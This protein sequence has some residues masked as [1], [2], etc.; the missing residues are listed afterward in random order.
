MGK[1]EELASGGT[2]RSSDKGARL[3]ALESTSAPKSASA[4]EADF[5]TSSLES[6]MLN[7]KSGKALKALC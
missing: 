5:S 2:R 7:S 4:S 1:V 6:Q 3:G